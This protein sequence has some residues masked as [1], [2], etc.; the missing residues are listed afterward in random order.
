[1]KTD[2]KF[3]SDFS[4]FVGLRWDQRCPNVKLYATVFR[5]SNLTSKVLSD[6]SC[7][8][9]RRCDNCVFNSSWTDV[10]NKQ[11][12]DSRCVFIER[13]VPCNCWNDT[14]YVRTTEFC[15]KITFYRISPS[16]FVR[17][18]WILH[19][20]PSILCVLFW[21][22]FVTSLRRLTNP[23]D[24]NSAWQGDGHSAAEEILPDFMKAEGSISCSEENAT[25]P[26]P[27]PD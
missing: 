6:F 17:H 13:R 1:M 26:C 23:L 9:E 2:T 3:C 27:E 12:L 21:S 16:L 11:L 24:Q 20:L 10:Q 4:R 22:S 25:G 18:S 15:L 8:K 14:P 7:S 19:T 5:E